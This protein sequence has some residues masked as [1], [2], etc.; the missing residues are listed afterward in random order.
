MT[1]SL[2]VILMECTGNITFALP[3]IITVI[4]AKWTGDFFNEVRYS[5]NNKIIMCYNN[6][7]QDI[8]FFLGNI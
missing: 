2:T 8:T 7:I 3:L 4:A 1:I 5:I 6:I